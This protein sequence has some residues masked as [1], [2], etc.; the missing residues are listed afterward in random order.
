M[1]RRGIT[2]PADRLRM[3]ARRQALF[4]ARDAMLAAVATPA[5]SAHAIAVPAAAPALQIVHGFADQQSIT[6][7]MQGESAQR[8][9]VETRPVA[10][11]GAKPLIQFVDLDPSADCSAMLRVFGLEP[12]TSYAYMVFAA[13]KAVLASGRFSTQ[14]LWQW[15]ADPPTV[16]IATGSCAYLNDGRFD[17]PGTLYGGSEEIFDA[18][19]NASPD[20]M[21]WLGDNIYLR[22]PEWSS[23][24]GI[25]KRYR[26]YRSHASLKRLWRAAPHVAIWDDHDFGPNDSDSSFVNKAWTLEMFRRYWPVPYAAPSDGLYGQI[27]QGDVDIFLLDDRSYRYP[28]RWPEGADKAM[29]GAAQM[30]WLKAAL[31]S[32]QAPFKVIA[33]G[34]QFWNQANRYESW[35]KFPAEQQLLRQWLDDCKIP[36]VLFLSGDRHF[37]QMLRIERP[38]LYPLYELTTSPLTAMPVREPG[39]VERE[40]PD[41]VAGSLLT[42]RNF[43]LLTV[44]GPRAERRLKIE[45]MDAKGAKRWEWQIGAHELTVDKKPAG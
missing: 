36:G 5:L 43:A 44:S 1:S 25:N 22:E 31:L 27:T 32:S 19:A 35:G 21:L 17:R 3:P 8:L 34:G 16:R 30:H 6:L 13:N 23:R 38:G 4:S 10:E 45:L 14:L 7:W 28:N 9:R 39:P 11:P 42:E 24:E 20:L 33:G 29:Y 26:Y 15:R 37:A 41:L 12:G 18:I 40:N 2:D